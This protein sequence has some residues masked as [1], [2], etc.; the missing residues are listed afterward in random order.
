MA[1]PIKTTTTPLAVPST[2]ALTSDEQITIGQVGLR[3][4]ID[5]HAFFAS[6]MLSDAD[7]RQAASVILTAVAAVAAVAA[8]PS[9]STFS[10]KVALGQAALQTYVNQH[11]TISSYLLTPAILK[12]ATQIVLSAV[13]GDKT[14]QVI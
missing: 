5:G 12:E 13:Q 3:N 7:L 1:A 6:K 10:Q 11:A 14:A 9:A 2:I 8:A 4:Y